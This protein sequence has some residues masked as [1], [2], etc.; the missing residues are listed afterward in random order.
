MSMPGSL[1]F[2]LALAVAL[3]AQ[4]ILLSMI[5]SFDVMMVP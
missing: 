3:T 2:S 1:H 5:F 4:L